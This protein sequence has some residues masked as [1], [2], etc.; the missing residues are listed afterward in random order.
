MS[1]ALSAGKT[2]RAEEVVLKAP[3]GRSISALMNATSIPSDDD[4]VE[5]LIVTLQDMTEMEEIER[6]RAEFLAMVSHELRTPLATVRGSVSALLDEF[7]EMH[8]A[9]VRQFHR[10]IF[11]QTDRMRALIADLL[12]VARIATGTCPSPRARRTS[13]S[14]QAR[15]VGT[16]TSA[17]TGTTSASRSHPTCH[18]LWQTSRASSKCLATC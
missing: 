15:P 11:E 9:E 6:M 1:Q 4:G 12:D 14:S 13:R 18:G 16:S 5:N 3:D 8:P 7:S 2:V 10:I 17:G